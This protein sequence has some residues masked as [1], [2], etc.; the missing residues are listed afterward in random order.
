MKSSGQWGTLFFMT[1]RNIKATGTVLAVAVRMALL[2]LASCASGAGAAVI[3]EKDSA[4]HSIQVKDEWGVRTLS[5]NGSYETQM[6]LSNPLEGHFEYIDYFHMPWVLNPGIRR[7]LMLGLGGGSIQRACQHYHTNA[8]IDTVELDPVVVEVAG[9]YFGVKETARHR[10]HVQDGR[11]F[12]VRTTNVYDAIIIDAYKTA[13]YGS[14]VP[15]HLATDEFFKLVKTRLS[16]NGVLAYNVIGT[17]RSPGPDLVGS[18]YRTLKHSF[19]QVYMFQ[20]GSGMNVVFVATRASA[21]MDY[22]RF[23]EAGTASLRSGIVWAPGFT[24]RLRAFQAGPPR[25]AATSYILTDDYAPVES[26][27]RAGLQ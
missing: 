16:T 22:T 17:V 7:V 19:P 6:S 3:F 9:K 12:L 10:V 24:L 25:S 26:L 15:S 5:F 21:P 20:A 2:P 1:R 8:M 11:V 13:R 14:S 4:Y 23:Q 27:A 18:V